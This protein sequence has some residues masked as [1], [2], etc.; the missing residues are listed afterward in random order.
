M[1]KYTA[2][3]SAMYPELPENIF[4]ALADTM[5]IRVNTAIEVSVG[6]LNSS[7]NRPRIASAITTPSAR[8]R[9]PPGHRTTSRD[10]IAPGRPP[11]RTARWA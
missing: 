2:C 1:P 7:G 11:S 4:Q 9:Y 5:K 10:V 8:T 6:L 3:P